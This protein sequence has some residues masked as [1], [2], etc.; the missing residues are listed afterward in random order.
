MGV[1]FHPEH[2]YGTMQLPAFLGIFEWL[3]VEAKA[4]KEENA[5]K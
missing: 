5:K 1:Q 3:I 2:L 4:A